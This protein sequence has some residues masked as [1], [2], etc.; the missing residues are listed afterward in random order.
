MSEFSIWWYLL[1]KV[2]VCLFG[3]EWGMMGH[4]DCGQKNDLEL[5]CEVYS[6]ACVAQVL[7]NVVCKR[8]VI[9]R[10]GR[11]RDTSNQRGSH[12]SWVK[13]PHA[14]Y[15]LEHS[16]AVSVKIQNLYSILSSKT[17][18]SLFLGKS[19]F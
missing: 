19:A 1:S 15:G 11:E 2:F 3:M 6:F 8:G 7:P 16:T 17:P 14:V 12:S 18:M 5:L 10:Q 13:C 9:T 4:E